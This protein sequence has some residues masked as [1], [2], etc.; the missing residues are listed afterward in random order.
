M[1][2]R[3]PGQAPLVSVVMPAFN[4]RRFVEESIAS[5]LGQ[6]LGD[7]ELIVIDDGSSDGTAD[8]ARA[9]G[10]GRLQVLGQANR[11]PSAA[12]NLGLSRARGTGY[13]AFIDADDRWAPEKLARQVAFMNAHPQCSIA[14]CFMR[15][16]SSHGR[17]LG[18]AGEAL[19]ERHQASIACG[20]SFPF[21]LSSF[22]VRR[23]ALDEVG[24]F[25]ESLGWPTGGSE[26]ID[27]LARLAHVGAVAC[28]PEVLGDY[29][30]H[31][32][33]AMARDRL[34][35]N[36]A[37]RFVRRRLAARRSGGDLTWTDFLATDRRTW[38]DRR[39]DWVEV[40]YR[41]AA[42]W[43][44]ERRY[45]KAF[46]HGIAALIVSPSYTI[47]RLLRQRWGRAIGAGRD[48]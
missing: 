29:R 12:R 3:T 40:C 44:A 34:N 47:R 5:V 39:Q 2:D 14:G 35:V 28:V 13:V 23:R 42:L 36:R 38:R 20:E 19:D 15:Y 17:A 16:V 41:G 33:S 10:D 26:D 1:T 8:V 48:A 45:A 32:S 24:G 7:L 43:Y 22:L 21:P 27:L 25:D 46:A 37:A 30:I 9:S 31:P 18:V 6:S 11:G 4:A